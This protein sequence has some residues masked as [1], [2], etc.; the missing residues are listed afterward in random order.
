MSKPTEWQKDAQNVK[1]ERV[2]FWQNGVMVTTQMTRGQAQRMVEVEI[3]Y[4]ISAQAIGD[5]NARGERRG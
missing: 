1:T 4:V 3:A 2:Q 5:L